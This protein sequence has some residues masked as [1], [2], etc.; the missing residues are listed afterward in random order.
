[1]AELKVDPSP[2]LSSANRVTRLVTSSVPF[3]SRRERNA[4]RLL[5]LLDWVYMVGTA[6]ALPHP[7]F[8]FETKK[9]KIIRFW[10][11]DIDN[12]IEGVV[13]KILEVVE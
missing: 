2:S 10:N 9:Y 6:Y 5:F 12:N 8:F 4:R 13:E 1:M 7:T 3:A 11:N